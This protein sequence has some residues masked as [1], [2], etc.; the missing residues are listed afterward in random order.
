ME[1]AIE[2][3]DSKIT[4]HLRQLESVSVELKALLI[5]QL[6]C[7]QV[8]VVD[9]GEHTGVH[10]GIWYGCIQKHILGT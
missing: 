2:A 8:F 1:F 3:A 4:H 10:S 7:H 5:Y 9:C 6:P